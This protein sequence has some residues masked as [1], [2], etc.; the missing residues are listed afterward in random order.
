MAVCPATEPVGF[1]ARSP[2]KGHSVARPDTTVQGSRGAEAL[3]PCAASL[4][5]CVS[6]V[7]RSI[8]ARRPLGI[9]GSQ[10]E[11]VGASVLRAAHTPRLSRSLLPPSPTAGSAPVTRSAWVT[12]R[13][14]PPSALEKKLTTKTSRQPD[15]L[16]DSILPCAPLLPT[17]RL[18][19]AEFESRLT[20]AFRVG[21]V[22]F[23]RQLF[24]TLSPA[25]PSHTNSQSEAK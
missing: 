13:S 10:S 3:C 17:F 1:A 23:S 25:F 21:A 14:N 18:L 24:L 19:S 7:A 5:R 2:A 9:V 22:T 20:A 12:R 15:E 6:F 8:P 11:L 4:E 16:K